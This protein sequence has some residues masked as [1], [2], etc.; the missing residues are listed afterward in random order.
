[1]STRHRPASTLR[2]RSRSRVTRCEH[3][4][5]I[6]YREHHHAT[7]AVT[8]A[9]RMRT[10]ALLTGGVCSNRVDRSYRCEH[11]DGWHLTSRRPRPPRLTGHVATTIA[12][13]TGLT[14]TT[15]VG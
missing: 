12:A 2:S 5:K 15:V 11:C 9:R 4:G 7:Q 3:T 1:M 10:H 8:A 13:A 14:T 6:R